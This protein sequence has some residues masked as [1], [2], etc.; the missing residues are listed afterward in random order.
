MAK[1]LTFIAALVFALT[2]A[3]Q[4]RPAK[5][6]F[7]GNTHTHTLKSD[8]DSSPE[9]VVRWY[10]E[11]GYD[12]LVI[13][14]H[15]QI[16]SVASG[17]RAFLLI[18]GEEV[19]DRLPKKPLHVNAIGLKRLVTPQGGTSP[20]DVLQHDVD[21][22]RSAGGI[23]MINHPNFVWAFGADV[24]RQL[25]NVKLL[26]IASGHPL[27]N[28]MGGGGFPSVEAMWDEV[29]TSGKTMYAVAVDDMHHL[30]W[31]IP[32]GEIALAQPG[33]GWVMVHAESLTTDAIMH[34]LDSGDFYAS[35][36][37]EI[38]DYTVTKKSMTIT[39]HQIGDAKF[40][41]FFIGSHGKVLRESITNPATYKIRGNEG[42]VRVKVIDS[43][44]K[45]AWTQPVRV[46]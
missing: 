2:S 30:K 35:T 5:Q 42:Y 44:G 20:A 25:Q 37:V 46:Q 6:W 43:N 27:V 17:D 45:A 19:T 18:P 7:K 4:T 32:K 38:A 22:V 16:T 1:A 9:E 26:E 33:K 10:R 34:A 13:T 41:T 40:R 8:G 14:D 24:L 36:G 11:H 39:I 23:P 21:A 28:M 29:L 31:E 3:E 12:F 15:D